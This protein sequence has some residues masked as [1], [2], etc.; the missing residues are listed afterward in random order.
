MEEKIRI[1]KF[2]LGRQERIKKG[3]QIKNI[4]KYGKR[5]RTDSLDCFYCES[6]ENKIALIVTKKKIKLATDRNKIKRKIREAYRLNKFTLIKKKYHMIF[7]YRPDKIQS[8][9]NIE[10]SVLRFF[11]FLESWN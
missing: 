4:I 1:K 8:F 7:F 10:I 3:S 9:R 11:N 5:F 6:A 2:S